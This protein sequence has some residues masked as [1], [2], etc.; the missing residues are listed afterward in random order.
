MGQTGFS[1]T[2]THV[3]STDGVTPVA[4]YSDPYPNGFL[5]PSGSSL[6]LLTN[7]GG[8]IS[9]PDRDQKGLYLQNWNLSI[10]RQLTS[11]LVLDVAY[12]G[13]K[14]THLW[15]DLQYNQLPDQ[16]LF[17]RGDLQRVVPNPFRGIVPTN[18]PL[19]GPTTTYGQLL[20]PYPQFTSVNAIGATSGSS[21]YHALEIRG[22]KRFSH[23]LNFLA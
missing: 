2:T 6:G 21:I 3:S 22:E 16:Y 20:R 13:N 17:L 10:Q 18:Q 1:A 9:V 19:G 23:G 12:A 11:D 7:V 5:K 4:Y 15:Q 8:G 14:G